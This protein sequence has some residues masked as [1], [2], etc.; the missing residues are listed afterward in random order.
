MCTGKSQNGDRLGA[1]SER[2][3]F[4]RA[5][6]VLIPEPYRAWTS[7]GVRVAESSKS[8]PACY[9]VSNRCTPRRSRDGMALAQSDC[10]HGFGPGGIVRTSSP[11]AEQDTH[12]F[13]V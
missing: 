13:M 6:V 7:F 10:K 3:G 8:G 1:S 4:P 5:A 12:D 11:G 2:E 9:I